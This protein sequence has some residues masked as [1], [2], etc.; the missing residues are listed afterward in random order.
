M[1]KKPRENAVYVT[2]LPMDVTDEKLAELFG[3][4]GVIKVRNFKGQVLECPDRSFTFPRC[5]LAAHPGLFVQGLL[6]C[7]ECSGC[8]SRCIRRPVFSRGLYMY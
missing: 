5:L 4:I 6:L 1:E 3:S 2:G 8:K 7:R